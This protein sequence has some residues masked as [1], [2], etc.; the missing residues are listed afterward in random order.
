MTTPVKEV[1]ISVVDPEKSLENEAE[2]TDVTISYD[3]VDYTFNTDD[4]DDVEFML[5]ME[6]E[7]LATAIQLLLGKSQFY[8]F[9]A[10]KRKLKELNDLVELM[11]EEKG[12]TPGE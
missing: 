9:I 2:S 12:A 5:A 7:Q 10:K 6:K 4:M 1:N 11:F 3:G 8:K